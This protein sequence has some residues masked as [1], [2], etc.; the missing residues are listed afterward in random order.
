MDRR[1][2]SHYAYCNIDKNNRRFAIA[3]SFNVT[4][5]NANGTKDVREGFKVHCLPV[6]YNPNKQKIIV[7]TDR[8][9]YITPNIDRD[10]LRLAGDKDCCD[11]TI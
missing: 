8:Y 6:I 5:P 10:P 11:R 3:T 9:Y 1:V 7:G 2:T 4:Y